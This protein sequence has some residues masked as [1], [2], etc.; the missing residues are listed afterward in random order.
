MPRTVKEL[1]P[2]GVATVVETFRVLVAVELPVTGLVVKVP[3]APT[4]SPKTLRV[5]VQLFALPLKP[6]VT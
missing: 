3:V 2:P 4:G 5:T 1:E 6:I